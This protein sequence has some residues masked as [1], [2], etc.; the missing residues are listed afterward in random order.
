M[1][2]NFLIL[3]LIICIVQV[4]NAQYVIVG[5]TGTIIDYINTTGKDI[6]IP[7][8]IGGVTVTSIGDY[9]L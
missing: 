3:A 1:K 7:S 2:L 5:S 4:A 9:A 8:K 6:V